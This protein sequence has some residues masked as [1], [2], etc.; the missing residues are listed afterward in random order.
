MIVDLVVVDSHHA[1]A[2]GRT[3]GT[4]GEVV[5]GS[6]NINGYIPGLY[7]TVAVKIENI[8]RSVFALGDIIQIVYAG[9]AGNGLA[10]FPIQGDHLQAGDPLAGG[11][12]GIGL[13]VDGLKFAGY[14]PAVGA[15]V[16]PAGI[17]VVVIVGI[18]I[19][20]RNCLKPA[21]PHIGIFNCSEIPPALG[22]IVVPESKR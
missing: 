14:D 18:Q 16:I 19:F 22:F 6:V 3:A 17:A 8:G 5:V 7:G 15:A 20:V 11:V 9:N 21:G 4:E 1:R 13:A 10:V 2:S 12:K